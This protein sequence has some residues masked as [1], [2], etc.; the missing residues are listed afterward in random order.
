MTAA[1]TPA[2]RRRWLPRSLTARLVLGVVA[3]VVV[4]VVV[5]GTLTAVLL[6]SFLRT[7]LDQQLVS[8]ASSPLATLLTSSTGPGPEVSAPQRVYVAAY[9][10]SGQLQIFNLPRNLTTLSLESSDRAQ[11]TSGPARKPTS[12]TDTDGVRLRALWLPVDGQ[13]TDPSTGKTAFEH[14]TFIVGLSER[15]VTET[16]ARVLLLEVAI[17]AAAVV[18]AFVITATGMSLSLRPLRRITRTAQEVTAEM[19][20]EGTGL[21]RRV[22][23]GDSTTEVGELAASFN[24]ML[25]VVQTQFTARRESENRMRQFLADAS[26]ELRTPL[27]SIRGYAELARLGGTADTGDAIGR[28]ETEGTRMSRLV[29]DLLMLARGDDESETPNVRVL[30]DLADVVDEAV[31]GLRASYPDRPISI[32]TD[33]DMTVIGDPDQLLRALRNLLTNAA[34]HTRSGGPIRVESHKDGTFIL[35]RVIDAGPGLP[36]DEVKHVFERFWRADRARSRARGGS[37]LGLPIVAQIV[38]TH[39]GDVDFESSLD[40][41]STVTLR[42]PAAEA[43][44]R[45]EA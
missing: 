35:V 23:T 17:G 25:S 31:E 32:D 27:T 10:S 5:T 3:V 33:A 11:L 42:L 1:P 22:V 4:V 14:V 37:G 28:I 20:P 19:T 36:P 18:L 6:S 13:V 21:D 41:G 9:D 40:E 34:V 26:H 24:T 16:M 15:E 2:R 8:T 30:I 44:G 29:D 7:R 43:S 38:R 39:G 45:I 12:L